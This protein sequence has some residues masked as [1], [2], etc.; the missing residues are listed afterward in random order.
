MAPSPTLALDSGF[1][2]AARAVL[3]YLQE[4][5][6]LAFW[7][8]TRVENGRQTYL[9]LDD[10]NGYGLPRGGSHPWQDSF[11]IHMAAG[12]APDVA[13]DAQ[14]IPA[15]AAAGVNRAVAIG[16]YAGAVISEPD[17]SVFGAI[18]GIDPQVRSDD[19]ALVAAAPLLRL[20]GRLL[21][22]VLAADRSLDDV[23]RAEARARAEAETDALTGLLN[24]RAW[25][26][27]VELESARFA[28]L[29]DP[30]VVVM[31]DLD[32]LKSLNDEQGHAAGDAYLQ[33]TAQALS[34]AVRQGD[35]VARLG[36]DEFAVLLSGC[37]EEHAPGRL[38][39]IERT[40]D[41][42]GVS[43]SLGWAPISVLKGFGAALAEADAAMYAAKQAGRDS[44][45][46]PRVLPQRSASSGS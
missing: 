41:E 16:S 24:R 36:G 26:R 2:A 21:T 13:L 44:G 6:P 3:G 8:V 12:S 5:V 40:L 31:L 10:D 35:A 46:A 34:T 32:G 20:L 11:C 7:S 1:D 17:G 19:P 14:A 37:T 29:A 27:L 4:H 18:C 33:A 23:A 38:A 9:Y 45:T 15:Y 25:E 28:R 39:E 30:T 43:G 42:A 22:M